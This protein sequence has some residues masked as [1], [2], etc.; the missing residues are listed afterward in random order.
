MHANAS[1]LRIRT[2]QGWIQEHEILRADIMGWN[3]ASTQ[4]EP[5]TTTAH[6]LF[7]DRLRAVS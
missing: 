2:G 3:V 4:L 1:K 6:N 7:A 5:L